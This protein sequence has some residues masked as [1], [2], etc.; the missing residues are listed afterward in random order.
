MPGRPPNDVEAS[1]IQQCINTS[2]LWG[3]VGCERW[4]SFRRSAE[5]D[6][7]AE[8]ARK[9]MGLFEWPIVSWRNDIA[10]FMG[11]RWA[12][13]NGLDAHDLTEVELRSRDK[14]M[15]LLAYCRPCTR[16][17]R[18]L[19]HADR[20][21]GWR[22]PDPA[23]AQRAEPSAG[24]HAAGAAAA[25]A[26]NGG[27]DPDKVAAGQ[28]QETLIRQG[29]HVRSTAE[30]TVRQPDEVTTAALQPSRPRT[31]TRE[32]PMPTSYTVSEIVERR[33]FSNPVLK[34]IGLCFVLLICDSYDV[35]ALSFAAPVLIKSWAL[36]PQAMGLV[37]SVGLFGLLV[38]SILFG[39][40][41]DKIGRK[42]AIVTGALA[43][44]VLTVAT[45]FAETYNQ[46]L[47]LRF[48][49]ALGLGGAVPNAVAL[50]TEFSPKTLRITSVGIIFAGYSVGD[51]LAGFLA[52]VIIS[53]YG[54][55]AMFFVGGGLSLLAVL[56][57]AAALPESLR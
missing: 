14:M 21:P 38:G 50:V 35:A 57:F 53:G 47:T 27:V 30:P 5:Y 6:A 51:I 18:R 3:G 16:L 1:S 26:A 17:R 39:R 40:M 34:I 7:F 22:P 33:G 10:V 48:L 15:E 45:G 12:G 37:F 43:F 4:L 23:P 36:S 20:L 42:R 56:A 54:W 29:A 46:L 13:C 25:L 31:N 32:T 9:E 55:P 2:W 19:D 24:G 49:A 8:Q 44:G 28:L 11:P 52:A 41:G